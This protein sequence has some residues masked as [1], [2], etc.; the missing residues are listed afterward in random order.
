M[1]YSK[2]TENGKIKNQLKQKKFMS[3]KW[4]RNCFDWILIV[5]MRRGGKTNPWAIWSK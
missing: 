2:P 5:G 3:L 4:R 1:E